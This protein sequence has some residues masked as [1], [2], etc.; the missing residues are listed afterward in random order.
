MENLKLNLEEG[1]TFFWKS[2]LHYQS[3]ITMIFREVVDDRH[4]RILLKVN[5]VS[6]AF[7]YVKSAANFNERHCIVDR[8]EGRGKLCLVQDFV[9]YG[10]EFRPGAPPLVPPSTGGWVPCPVDGEGWG[11]DS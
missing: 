7:L 1:S 5:E 8:R 3:A 6:L 10:D 9:K 2:A 11:G 4:A